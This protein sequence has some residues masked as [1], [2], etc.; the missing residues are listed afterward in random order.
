MLLRACFRFQLGTE[1]LYHH[2]KDIMITFCTISLRVFSKVILVSPSQLTHLFRK[3]VSLNTL[4]SLTQSALSSSS[5]SRFANPDLLNLGL[6]PVEF[7]G[8]YPSVEA[9]G[10]SGSV[11]EKRLSTC[12][13]CHSVFHFLDFCRLKSIC[14][15]QY[16]KATHELIFK[17][18]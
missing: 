7:P 2:L 15:H 11:L 12:R 6:F 17:N 14:M 10:M 1:I 5:A 13:Q 8:S 4:A 18:A 3:L 16:I 9:H